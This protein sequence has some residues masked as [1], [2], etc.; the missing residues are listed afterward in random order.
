MKDYEVIIKLTTKDKRKEI[1][2]A[3][4]EYGCLIDKED[5]N[6]F[7]VNAALY[8]E[9]M[10]YNIMDCYTHE[11]LHHCIQAE[12][13]EDKHNHPVSMEELI[14]ELMGYPQ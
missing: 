6:V 5:Y 9:D 2:D 1:I 13:G 4:N 7:I 3:K 11:F 10:I 14:L 8:W 12:L